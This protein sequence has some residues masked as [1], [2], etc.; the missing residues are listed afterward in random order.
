MIK[1]SRVLQ[2]R[3]RPKLYAKLQKLADKMGE[4]ISEFVRRILETI[5]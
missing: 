2:V 4:S 5:K 3:L 1:K